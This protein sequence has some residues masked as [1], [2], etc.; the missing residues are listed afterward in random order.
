MVR[1]ANCSFTGRVHILYV[2]ICDILL[3]ILKHVV[4]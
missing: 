3:Q 1:N 4:K 2:Q